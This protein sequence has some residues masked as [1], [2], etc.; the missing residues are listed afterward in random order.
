MHMIALA[1]KEDRRVHDGPLS[2]T[3]RQCMPKMVR[4][5]CQNI[6]QSLTFTRFTFFPT[7]NFLKYLSM[8]GP[9]FS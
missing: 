6:G 5:Q 2:P 3:S 8:L 4:I 7:S 1:V 9:I